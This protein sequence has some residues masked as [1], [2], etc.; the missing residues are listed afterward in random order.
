TWRGGF[1]KDVFAYL[2]LAK[3]VH[4]GD[5]SFKE[6]ATRKYGK[7]VVDS[8]LSRSLNEILHLASLFSVLSGLR[9]NRSWRG[10]PFDDIKED[11]AR[12]IRDRLADKSVDSE[13]DTDQ[14]SARDDVKEF[15]RNPDGSVWFEVG[16]EGKCE[17]EGRLLKHCGNRHAKPGE[18]M[19]SLRIPVGNNRW[20]PLLSFI[21]NKDMM[22]I[23]GRAK[24][25]KRPPKKY[26]PQIFNLLMDPRIKGIDVTERPHATNFDILEFDKGMLRELLS[27]RYCQNQDFRIKGYHVQCEDGELKAIYSQSGSVQLFPEQP[28]VSHDFYDEIDLSPFIDEIYNMRFF[29]DRFDYIEGRYR[30]NIRRY[31]FRGELLNH[32]PHNKTWDLITSYADM[33]LHEY[34]PETVFLMFAYDE[35]IPFN[36][37]YNDLAKI[38]RQIQGK[39]AR[40]VYSGKA[41][42]DDSFSFIL[43]R[44]LGLDDVPANTWKRLMKIQDGHLYIS[45]QLNYYHPDQE[46]WEF[47]A[48]LYLIGKAMEKLGMD[49]PWDLLSRPEYSEMF[50]DRIREVLENTE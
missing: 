49:D 34:T 45:P 37:I 9:V 13:Q 16:R 12:T 40:D 46:N 15:L 41:M 33:L 8:I 11:F 35:L 24:A 26:H 39:L 22:V 43:L 47:S 48:S 1:R 27:K 3:R 5:E 4:S 30:E 10:R 32:V 38:A 14:H 44:M 23:E 25:N 6:R 2:H 29:D 18:K 7:K 20:K 31:V 21:L 42:D 28:A 17:I 19:L 36:R 50:R